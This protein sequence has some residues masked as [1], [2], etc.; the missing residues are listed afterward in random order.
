MYRCQTCT[1][2][3]LSPTTR[4]CCGCRQQIVLIWAAQ[5]WA[6]KYICCFRS[7]ERVTGW[8]VSICGR[9][10]FAARATS[11]LL[12]W[13]VHWV[14][15]HRHGCE[16]NVF[17]DCLMFKAIEFI[18]SNQ[19]NTMLEAHHVLAESGAAVGALQ[20]MDTGVEVRFNVCCH[21]F[22]SIHPVRLLFSDLSTRR[23][24]HALHSQ[25]CV[26]W[27][28]NGVLMVSYMSFLNFIEM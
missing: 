24:K 12:R 27:L 8:R 1:W 23:D 26:G 10:S 3:V 2:R 5:R 6:S 18:R 7:N 20:A 4:V 21:C 28:R 25:R 9:A 11:R 14:G 19:V 17:F 22:D 13:R 16:T 15:R